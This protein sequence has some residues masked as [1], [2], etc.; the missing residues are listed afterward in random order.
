[1]KAK[2]LYDLVAKKG[3]LLKGKLHILD[4]SDDEDVNSIYGEG[5]YRVYHE[6]G[7]CFDV[8]KTIIDWDIREGKE[9]D[10]FDYFM[11][12]EWD[13]FKNLTIEKAIELIKQ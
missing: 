13:G 7:Y 4:N 5:L 1:M 10:N 12:S 6:D 8:S 9:V 2:E 3:E 11:Y